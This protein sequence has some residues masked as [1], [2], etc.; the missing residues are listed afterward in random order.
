MDADA[1]RALPLPWP[2]HVVAGIVASQAPAALLDCVLDRL[3]EDTPGLIDLVLHLAAV[4]GVPIADLIPRVPIADAV[5]ARPVDLLGAVIDSNALTDDVANRHRVSVLSALASRPPDLVT[6][7]L[8]QCPSLLAPAPLRIMPSFTVDLLL[9]CIRHGAASLIGRAPDAIGG[10]ACRAYQSAP[11]DLPQPS[12]N[13]LINLDCRWATGIL[14]SAPS[15]HPISVALLWAKRPLL[16]ACPDAVVDVLLTPSAPCDV[17]LH[18]V[19]SVT[20]DER[21]WLPLVALVDYRD[22]RV[23]Q[24]AA[25]ALGRLPLPRWRLQNWTLCQEMLRVRQHA[26]H[27]HVDKAIGRLARGAPDAFLLTLATV[28][29]QLVSCKDDDPTL[30]HLLA[31]VV[32]RGNEYRAG[33]LRTLLAD[34][35]RCSSAPP[36][37]VPSVLFKAPLHAFDLATITAFGAA[38]SLFKVV[39]LVGPVGREQFLPVARSLLLGLIRSWSQPVS[40][41]TIERSLSVFQ[42]MRA[43]DMLPDLVSPMSASVL[44]ALAPEEVVGILFALLE[45]VSVKPQHRDTVPTAALRDLL[46]RICLNN[47]DRRPVA[48]FFASVLACC[49]QPSSA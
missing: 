47:I 16:A 2:P 34:R 37:G 49:R 11:F 32:G 31:S 3:P 36:A 45:Q 24:A 38:P 21:F 14:E 8:L 19:S 12:V 23:R 42:M 7:V 9:H 46:E 27:D 35:L 29:S 4:A 18:C 17:L 33:A 39:S 48:E 5:S 41:A 20:R 15:P 44:G 6:A 40:K 28:F 1:L 30:F 26:P 22:E 25:Q 10:D 43:L 13:A